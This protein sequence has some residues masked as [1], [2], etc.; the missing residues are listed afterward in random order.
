[1][2]QEKP[3]WYEAPVIKDMMGLMGGR[4][5]RGVMAANLSSKI[6]IGIGFN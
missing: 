5:L 4:A 1:M 2:T 3:A 6:Y